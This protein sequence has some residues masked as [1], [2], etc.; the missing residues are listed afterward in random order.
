M[1]IFQRAGLALWASAA[2]L[3]AACA[4]QQLTNSWRSPDFAGPPPS[5]VLVLGL[6]SS[7]AS[8]R[9]FEDGFSQALGTAG[10][11]AAAAYPQL[12]DKGMIPN[13]RLKAALTSSG[14]QAVLI[15]RLLKVD[16]EVSVTPAM[17]PGRMYGGFYGFYGGAWAALPPSVDTYKIFTI[18]TTLWDMRSEKVIWTG[19]T[20]GQD[21]TDVAKA[22]KDLAAVL[23]AQMKKDGVI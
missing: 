19:T 12:P 20:Q 9:I 6:S 21:V 14:A 13:D 7:D 4:T 3:L 10:V 15:T 8:R 2:L 18:E 5:K 23:I 11:S 22:T 17:P 1:S 16:Q